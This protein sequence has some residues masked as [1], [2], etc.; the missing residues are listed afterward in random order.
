MTRNSLVQVQ[1]DRLIDF[2]ADW[3]LKTYPDVALTG[4]DPAKHYLL[5]GHSLGRLGAPSQK[6]QSESVQ[7]AAARFGQS[8]D[9]DISEQTAAASGPIVAAPLDIA[10]IP[11]SGGAIYSRDPNVG[12]MAGLFIGDTELGRASA[13]EALAGIAGPVAMMAR[14]V[15]A[16]AP[17]IDLPGGQ[18]DPN[19]LLQHEQRNRP[20]MAAPD[21][22]DGPARIVNAWFSD[23][24][25]IR[26]TLEGYSD[27][28]VD[29]ATDIIR[30]W[31]VDATGSTTLRAVG[32]LKLPKAGPGFLALQLNDPLMPVLL[33]LSDSTG[34]SKG[35]A[36]LAFPSLLRGGMHAAE[37]AAHQLG[38][39]PMSEVWRLSAALLQDLRAGKRKSGFAISRIAVRLDG[40][41]GA[42]PLLSRPV[43]NWLKTVFNLGLTTADDA[44]QDGSDPGEAWMAQSLSNGTVRGDGLTLSL[45]AQAIPTLQALVSRRMALPSG[46]NRATGP[47]LV[48]EAM[49]HRPLWS[50]CVPMD[51]PVSADMPVLEG[52]GQQAAEQDMHWLAPLHLAVI[53]R[54]GGT[55]NDTLNLFPVAPDIPY[56]EQ[57]DAPLDIA[58]VF[59][60]TDAEQAVHALSSLKQQAE[61]T[62]KEVLIRPPHGDDNAQMGAVFAVAERLFAGRA[63]VIEAETGTLADMDAILDATQ[64]A[65]ILILDESVIF[66]DPRILPKMAAELLSRDDIASIGCTLMYQGIKGKSVVLQFGSAGLFPAGVS[67]V[68]APRLAVVEPNILKA[69]PACTYPVLANTFQACLIRRAAIADT[70]KARADLVG[71]AAVDLHFGLSTQAAGWRNLC[72]SIVRAGTTRAPSGRDEIDPF[73]LD[74]LA[75]ARWDQLLSSV[76]VL[77]E[78]RG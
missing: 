47:Y 64:Q 69:L 51:G 46:V 42:E 7:D 9:Q 3:Y 12:L 27:K 8:A 67:F 2:D 18:S 26:L 13:A 63:R 32:G 24:Q 49:S 61:I 54:P 59:T 62:V 65:H 38:P 37:R 72:T 36:L 4:L 78:L 20:V 1:D 76:T 25:T 21:F 11:A 41:T 31:Q 14:M 19:L 6:K 10:M 58:V 35:Y 23:A 68:S 33:E 28:G 75:P 48:S 17:H 29:I 55:I 66:Q 34:S 57:L 45:P 40:A 56:L 22:L 71:A 15:A 5:C 43:R 53:A 60:G 74:C 52:P 77:R 73:G 16:P 70:C 50:V 44:K 30:A 39:D